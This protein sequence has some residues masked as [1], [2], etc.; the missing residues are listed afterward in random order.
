LGTSNQ[1]LTLFTSALEESLR[2]V[3]RKFRYVEGN[4]E[5]DNDG[6]GDGDA[7]KL[8]RAVNGE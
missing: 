1:I 7:L 3:M 6:H 4:A 5:A 8:K 2:E